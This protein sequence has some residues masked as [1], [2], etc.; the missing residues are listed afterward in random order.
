LRASRQSDGG[1]GEGGRE[2]EFHD[3]FLMIGAHHA[4]GWREDVL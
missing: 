4:E 2:E 1:E 3:E